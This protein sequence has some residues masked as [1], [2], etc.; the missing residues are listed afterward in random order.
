M[1]DPEYAE[2]AIRKIDAYTHN[3]IFPGKRLL[4]TYETS[5]YTLNTS[6]AKMLI[7]EHLL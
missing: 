2:K 7:Q 3:G 6:V 1:D 5:N 4:V